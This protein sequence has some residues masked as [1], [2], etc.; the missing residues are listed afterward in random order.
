MI[1]LEDSLIELDSEV[2]D[3]E[4]SELSLDTEILRT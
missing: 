3:T 2:E 1:L 4:I